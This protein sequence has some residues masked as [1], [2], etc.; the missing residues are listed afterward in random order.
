MYATLFDLAVT[1]QA[2]T[3]S[4]QPGKL[5]YQAIGDA[6]YQALGHKRTARVLGVVAE[7]RDST[8]PKDS[9]AA[10]AAALLAEK[11]PAEDLAALRAAFDA[12]AAEVVS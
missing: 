2:V 10:A 12:I 8:T 4:R 6:M 11:V 1:F 3:G 7:S 5:A 9:A